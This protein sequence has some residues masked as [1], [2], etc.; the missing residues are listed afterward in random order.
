[1]PK[2]GVYRH[3]IDIESPNRTRNDQ[4][5]TV[6][7]SWNIERAIWARIEPFSGREYTD[8]RKVTTE[9]THRISIRYQPGLGILA[10]WRFSFGD[11]VFAIDS[12]PINIDERNIELVFI[13]R[14]TDRT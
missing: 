1:M 11:R 10:D 5:E 14:E 4:G 9:A 6:I 12:P 13:C 3:R 2:A 7:S 8:D